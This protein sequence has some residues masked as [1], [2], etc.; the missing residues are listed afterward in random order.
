MALEMKPVISSMFSEIGYD[1]DRFILAVTYKSTKDTWHHSGISPELYDDLV[2]AKSVGQFFNSQ[3]KG[4]FSAAKQ[5]PQDHPE[6]NPPAS[7]KPFAPKQAVDASPE[8]NQDQPAD[9]K[10][11]ADAI[12][13]AMVVAQ[14]AKALVIHTPAEFQHAGQELVRIAGEKKKRIAWFKP[15]KDLAFAAH[16][17]ICARETEA[18]APLIEAERHIDMGIREY[19]TEEKRQREAEQNRIDA[20]NRRKA[21]E[22][23]DARARQLAEEDAAALNAQGRPEEAAAVLAAPTMLFKEVPKVDGLSFAEDWDFE[24]TGSVPLSHDFYTLDEKKIRSYAK[25]LKQHAKVEGIRFFPIERSR[26]KA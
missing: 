13:T 2:N 23:A 16:R 3:I 8:Y 6:P 22:E 21:Q 20:E 11:E 18:L 19:R 14:K 24:V 1:E 25:R 17:A 10:D 15:M 4:K 7:G 5:G 12:A 26:K 9:F